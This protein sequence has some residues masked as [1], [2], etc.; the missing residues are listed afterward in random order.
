M[1]EIHEIKFPLLASGQFL[2]PR[3]RERVDPVI[4]WGQV[5]DDAADIPQS[6][7]SPPAVLSYIDAMYRHAGL[8]YPQSIGGETDVG[9]V[10][11]NGARWIRLKAPSL[12]VGTDR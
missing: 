8:L 4:G 9:L 12:D 7:E 10:D 1:I 2:N 6:L 11:S 5:P 3:Y